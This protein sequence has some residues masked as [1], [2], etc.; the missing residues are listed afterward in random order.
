[1]KLVVDKNLKNNVYSVTLQV[2]DITDTD[3]EKFSD[4]GELIV[5]VGGIITEKSVEQSYSVLQVP[6]TETKLVEILDPVTEEPILDSESNPVTKEVIVPVLDEQEQPI[7]EDKLDEF[8]KPVW[9]LQETSVDVVLAN[10]GKE[11]VKFPSE[12][13]ITRSFEV[14]EYGENAEKVALAYVDLIKAELT[15]KILELEGKTD[16]FSGKVEY[17]LNE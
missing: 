5:N 15:A 7:M 12:F 13:P 2:L 9:K 17:Q 8:G 6:K 3:R 4:F 11:L 10:L 16:T 14:S 1:M